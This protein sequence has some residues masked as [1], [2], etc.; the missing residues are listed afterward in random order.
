MIKPYKIIGKQCFIPHA[1]KFKYSLYR[2]DINKR[3]AIQKT[4]TTNLNRRYAILRSQGFLKSK[5]YGVIYT[6]SYS[7]EDIGYFDWVG[8]DSGYEQ[9]N[10][11]IWNTGGSSNRKYKVNLV[12][13]TT[14]PII[15]ED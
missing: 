9:Y 2:G 11:I 7:D 4:K 13:K 8:E 10:A 6:W 14:E 1:Y 3:Y 5:R 12:S 15:I